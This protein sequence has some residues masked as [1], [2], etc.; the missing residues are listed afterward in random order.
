MSNPEG[1][2]IARRLIA[3]EAR[4]QTGFLDLGML[5]LTEL[6]EEI[7]QLTHLRRLNLGH[8]FYDEAGKSHN[9]SNSLAAN[10]FSNV[11]LPD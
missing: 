10:D 6:P 3:E 9:S 2:E 5:G 1:L 8:W 7:H 4:Q 11:S